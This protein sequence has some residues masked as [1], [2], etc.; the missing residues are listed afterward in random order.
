MNFLQSEDQKKEIILLGMILLIALVHGLCHVFIVPPW[1]HYDEPSHFEY[2]WVIA[3]NKTLPE[4][5]NYSWQMRRDVLES[6]INNGFFSRRNA[7]P[8]DLD[9]QDLRIGGNAMGKPPAYYILAALPLILFPSEDVTI[10][11]YKMRLVSL[12]LYLTIVIIGWK[13]AK[14]LA[15]S[16]HALRFFLPFTLATL[17]S[18]TNHMT[19]VN[20]DVLATTIFSFFLLGGVTLI[21][22]GITLPNLIWTFGVAVACLWI[23]NTVVFAMPIL[24]ISIAFY[25]LNKNSRPIIA[26]TS[27]LFAIFVGITFVASWGDSAYWHRGT[28]QTTTTRVYNP[29]APVGEYNIQLVLSP[30]VLR[31]DLV[32]I[33]Q[34]VPQSTVRKLSGKVVTLGAWIWS[35]RPVIVRSPV[36]GIDSGE[37][38][39]SIKIGRN[40]RFYSFRVKVPQDAYRIWVTLDPLLDT[41]EAGANLAINYDGLI[42]AEGKFPL[43]KL[44]S[45]DNTNGEQGIWGELPFVN[46]LRNSSA[47]H[48][49]PLIRPSIDKKLTPL[50]G[51]KLFPTYSLQFLI[52]WEGLNWYYLLERRILFQ[53]FWAQ[54]GW[55]EVTLLGNKPYRWIAFITLAGI[56]GA[57]IAFIFSLKNGQWNKIVSF[58]VFLGSAMCTAWLITFLRGIMFL[59]STHLWLP[60]SRYAFPVVIPTLLLLN[61]GWLQLFDFADRW[62]PVK[63][64]YKFVVLTVFFIGLDIFSIV[65]LAKY[66]YG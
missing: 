30:E 46:L 55:G 13:V 38:F 18:F 23:K 12:L 33:Y 61:I 2:A 60:V 49:W 5:Q 53:T 28:S 54:F 50:L 3:N 27:L 58:V 57:V 19:A 31:T 63:S 44:P 26:W 32:P 66:Y 64:W 52:D 56:I 36:L 11:L 16:R 29:Q 43:D 21:R 41:N 1:E 15:P 45:F 17:P 48:A 8:P 20:N 4:P 40:P 34:P 24:I 51:G 37:W 35:D 42:L 10:D 14:E 65:S 22:R 47:E 9:V 7:H 39:K 62:P 25:L 59:P 6:M